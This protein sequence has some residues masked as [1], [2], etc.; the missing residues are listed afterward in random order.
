VWDFDPDRPGEIKVATT[1]YL[2]VPLVFSVLVG[3][4]CY[5]LRAAMDYL[6]Y[7]LAILDSGSIVDG[8]QFP[9]E[10][11]KKGFA[12][13]QN[14]GWL[15]GLNSPHVA[16]IEALQP[17]RG[18]DWTKILRD[19]SNPDKHRRLHYNQGDFMLEVYPAADRL[20]FLNLPGTV[21][22]ARDPVTG[23][24]VHVQI[25][26][27]LDIQFSDGT[28]V[29]QTLQKIQAGVA[30]TLEAFKPEFERSGAA[31]SAPP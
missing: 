12:F 16:A 13:R 23:K 6:V 20:R 7:E 9:I 19:L 2:G 10:G 28:P 14:G 21:S 31:H 18:C 11:K 24:E 30:D 17:Y 15:N 5:N 3:E 26:L 8:T 25:N 22:S 1:S 4:I 29:I 27:T